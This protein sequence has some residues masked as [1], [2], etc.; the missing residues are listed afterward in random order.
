MTN[1]IVHSNDFKSAYLGAEVILC[2]WKKIR[3][4]DRE[5]NIYFLC[6]DDPII[7]TYSSKLKSG[8]NCVK[9]TKNNDWL[10]QHR[11]LFEMWKWKY[12]ND[13]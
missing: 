8:E 6:V 1:F 5:N 9:L 11:Y 12:I 10:S 4:T 2:L 3:S 13:S 7:P